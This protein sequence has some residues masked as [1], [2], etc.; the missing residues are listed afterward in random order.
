MIYGIII[1]IIVLACLL[2][3]DGAALVLVLGVVA[4]GLVLLSEL[5]SIELLFTL[6][7]VAVGIIIVVVVFGIIGFLS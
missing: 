5:F 3:E 6:G 2:G 4:L 1:T 7:K